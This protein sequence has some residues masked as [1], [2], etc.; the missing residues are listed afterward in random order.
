MRKYIDVIFIFLVLVDVTISYGVGDEFRFPVLRCSSAERAAQSVSDSDILTADKLYQQAIAESNAN[1]YA[2]S[3]QLLIDA[4]GLN[5]NHNE[6]RE[7]FGYHLHDGKWHTNWEINKL[8]DHVDHPQF[9]W[10]KKDYVKRYEAG[11]RMINSQRW[12]SIDDEI[13]FRTKIQNGWKITTQH[14]EII[15]NH[16]L[17]EGVTQSRKLEHL[18]DAWQLFTYSSLSDNM[19]VKALFQKKGTFFLPLQRKVTIYRNKNDYTSDLMKIEPNITASNGYYLP[20]LKRAYFFAASPE[21]D[22]DEIESIRRVLLHEGSHQLFF[23][24]RST[25]RPNEPPGS[26]YN[27][28]LVEGLAMFM[29]T[30]RIKDNHYVLGD[31]KDERLYAAKYNAQNLNFY[32][33]FAKIVKLGMNDYQQQKELPKLYSQSAAMT[34]FLMFAENGKY[35]KPLLKLVRLIHNGLDKP[36]SLTKLTACSYEELDK[37]YNEF[38]KKIP[39]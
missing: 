17:E 2:E 22:K 1:N 10:I 13:K 35:R 15:T 12:V 11:E 20:K 32:I 16:S 34:H 29:E 24:P 38:L 30:L 18:H 7:I 26:R 27:C 9:G 39:D 37:K 4:I 19:R 36:D 3:I 5:P 33:P 8:K 28:W 6:I 23:D 31:I 25:A 14:Y 21:M